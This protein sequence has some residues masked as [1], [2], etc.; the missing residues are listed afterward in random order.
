MSG[1]EIISKTFYS[2]CLIEAVKAKLK[3]WHNITIK[4]I[5]SYIN[6]DKGCHYY[7]INKKEN[8]IYEFYGEKEDRTN[9]IFF[10]GNIVKTSK[11]RQ[12]ILLDMGVR[13]LVESLEKQFDFQT[14]YIDTCR[15]YHEKNPNWELYE[16]SIPKSVFIEKNPYPYVLGCYRE[17]GETIIKVYKIGDKN[18]LVNPNNDPIDW[19]KRCTQPLPF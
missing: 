10:R 11:K 2:N 7:W 9:R 16:E 8:Q 18:G 17:Q 15:K 5:P 12:E 13:N 14:Y 4:R 6:I 1:K 3:D 19:W